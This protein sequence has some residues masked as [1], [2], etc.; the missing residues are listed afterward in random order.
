MRP[1]P[2]ALRGSVLLLTLWGLFVLSALAVAL[3]LVVLGR[4]KLVDRVVTEEQSRAL[5]R[6]V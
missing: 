3:G 4:L 5:A 2:V 6:A 1:R